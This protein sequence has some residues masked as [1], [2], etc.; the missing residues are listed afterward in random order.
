M[1]CGSRPRSCVS[2]EAK[3]VEKEKGEV[4]EKGEEKARAGPFV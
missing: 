3:G 1:R 2:G 4:K